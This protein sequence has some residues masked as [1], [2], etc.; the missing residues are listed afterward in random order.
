MSGLDVSQLQKLLNSDPSTKIA[1]FGVGSP[2]NETTYFG[3]R[4]AVA[5]I[6]FQE[7][8]Y[9]DVLVPASLARGTGFVGPLTIAKL[10]SIQKSTTPGVSVS[11]SPNLVPRIVPA[12]TSTSTSP[13]NPATNPQ[14]TV[15]RNNQPATTSTTTATR[16]SVR[17]YAPISSPTSLG[18][19]SARNAF[20]AVSPRDLLIFGVSNLQIKPG[21]TLSITGYG[22]DPDSIVHIGA[23]TAP[24]VS[25]SSSDIRLVVPEIS[26]GTYDLWVTNSRG[27]SKTSSPFKF[28]I[29]A[30]TD[31]RPE[32]LSVTPNSASRNAV[33][34]VTATRLD[35]SNN[36]IH[37]TLGTL[38]NLNSSDGKTLTFNVNDL[39][40]ASM[41][42]SNT[43]VNQ[44]TVSFGVKNSSGLS[45][46][47]GYFFITK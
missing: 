46:N 9:K 40:N 36:T 4:T 14:T 37:S 8:Y 12:I 26:Y 6:K 25:I 44:F 13:T 29:G 16:P 10:N 32:I 20:M 5:V 33:I 45:S 30:T 47:Y 23:T 41:F 3:N 42:F 15:P 43:S 28:T 24:T 31:S 22:F 18:T 1:T 35:T 11:T 7:K 27:S 38:R 34:K 2:G 39:P 21:D 19:I 17:P